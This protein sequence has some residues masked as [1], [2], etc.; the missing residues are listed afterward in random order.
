MQAL[1]SPLPCDVSLQSPLLF[2]TRAVVPLV[3]PLTS[4]VNYFEDF[5]LKINRSHIERELYLLDSLLNKRPGIIAFRWSTPI[6][7]VELIH[8]T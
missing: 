2:L 3:F 8:P 6:S 7:S 4:E 1:H 5:F